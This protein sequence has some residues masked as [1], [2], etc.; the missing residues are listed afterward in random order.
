MNKR[1]REIAGDLGPFMFAREATFDGTETRDVTRADM[2]AINRFAL[3]ELSPDDVA[4]FTLNLC[5]DQIDRH[6]SRFPKSELQ[7]INK[8]VVGKPTMVSHDMSELPRGRFFKSR[9]VKG[10]TGPQAI[11]QSNEATFVQPDTYILRGE[12]ND[13]FIR[14]IEAGIYSGTSIGF[15]FETAECSVCGEDMRGC[16]HWPGDDYEGERCHYIMRNV[17]DVFEGSIVSLGSQGTEVV[18]ARDMVGH[19]IKSFAA[20]V[21]EAKDATDAIQ[22]DIPCYLDTIHEIRERRMSLRD[23]DGMLA[24]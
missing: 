18:G 19:S 12:R 10:P 21:R 2:N 8:M 6:C 7:K 3:R 20:A 11:T 17:V 1:S 5:N 23:D 22:P 15:A 9:V 24:I 4:V 13:D 14:H 16:A